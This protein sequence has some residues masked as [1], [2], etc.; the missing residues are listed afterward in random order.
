MVFSMAQKNKKA[1]SSNT[2][3]KN[4][5]KEACKKVVEEISN[6]TNEVTLDSFI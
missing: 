2:N 4:E 6:K 1:D 3:A 5:N